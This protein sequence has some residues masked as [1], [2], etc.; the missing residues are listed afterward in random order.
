MQW[1]EFAIPTSYILVDQEVEML[2]HTQ[3]QYKTLI[4]LCSLS[5][6]H[7]HKELQLPMAAPST[8]DK[9]SNI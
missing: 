1:L 7:V 5:Q 8:R 9:Y 2:N 4:N 6:P 3:G